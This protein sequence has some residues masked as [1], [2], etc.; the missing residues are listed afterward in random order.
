[1]PVWEHKDVDLELNQ[2]TFDDSE[3]TECDDSS[4]TVS[5]EYGRPVHVVSTRQPEW[6]TV[7]ICSVSR[8]YGGPEEGGWYYDLEAPDPRTARSFV[9]EDFGEAFMYIER[10][11]KKSSPTLR[12]VILGEKSHTWL[13]NRSRPQYR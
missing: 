11:R 7:V 10:Q 5:L 4:Q 6:V 8:E 1:M 9:K 2:N 3:V 12:V 13:E